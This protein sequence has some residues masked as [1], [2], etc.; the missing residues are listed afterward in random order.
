[1]KALQQ[2]LQ[3]TVMVEW[4]KPCGKMGISHHRIHTWPPSS[5]FNLANQE[6]NISHW[7]VSPLGLLHMNIYNTQCQGSAEVYSISFSDQVI[8]VAEIESPIKWALLCL[9]DGFHMAKYSNNWHLCF[10]FEIQENWVL[11]PRINFENSF[12][13]YLPS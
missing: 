10:F 1:M 5:C 9:S 2:N 13:I 12:I 6:F 4:K 11:D 8:S 7:L 3:Y